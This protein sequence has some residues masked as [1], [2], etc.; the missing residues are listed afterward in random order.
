MSL[1]S[2]MII[3]SGSPFA[4]SGH[5]SVADDDHVYIVGGYNSEFMETDERMPMFR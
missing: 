3:C 4:R 5:R 1:F 2:M